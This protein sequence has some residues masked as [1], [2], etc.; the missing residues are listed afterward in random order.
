MKTE[1]EVREMI[2]KLEMASAASQLDDFRK[3]CAGMIGGLEWAMGNYARLE[4]IVN[5]V[6]SAQELAAGFTPASPT[7]DGERQSPPPE[8]DG[9]E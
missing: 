3:I 6:L 5:S 2:R 8:Q 9:P 1:A 4:P 7:S